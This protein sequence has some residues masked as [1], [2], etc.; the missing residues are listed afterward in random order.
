MRNFFQRLQ[1]Q[2]NKDLD[3]PPPIEETPEFRS[4]ARL[5]IHFCQSRVNR[6]SHEM[7]LED[8]KE[9][10]RTKGIT[11]IAFSNNDRGLELL[12]GT[13]HIYLTDP[14]SMRVHDIGEFV[15]V[16]NRK[17]K[18]LRFLNITH[19]LTRLVEGVSRI[20]YHHPHVSG[21]GEMCI[22]EGREELN[23]Y[24]TEGQIAPVARMLMKALYTVDQ[25]PYADARPFNWPVKEA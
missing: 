17:N 1:Q 7:I 4:N 13:E 3:E 20:T 16:I 2:H 11:H 12:L 23:E 5:Y 24:L 8:L 9:L 15:I 21:N 25:V 22:V 10:L 6:G 18:Q 14:K 19:P